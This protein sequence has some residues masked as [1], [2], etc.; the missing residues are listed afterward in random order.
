MENNF[1]NEMEKLCDMQIDFWNEFRNALA[2]MDNSTEEEICIM[3][4]KHFKENNEAVQ[5]LIKVKMAI[6]KIEG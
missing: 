5:Q 4:H 3:W 2:V 6:A 1:K